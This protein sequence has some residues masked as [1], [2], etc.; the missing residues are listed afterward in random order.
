[1]ILDELK[2]AVSNAT[3]VMASAETLIK[4]FATRLQEA[5]DVAIVNG[6]TKEQLEPVIAEVSALNTSS[7]ELANAITANTV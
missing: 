5:V 7:S 4:G 1:M 3:T 2:T 6:A